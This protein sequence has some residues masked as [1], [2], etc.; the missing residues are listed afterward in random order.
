L[1][2][3]RSIRRVQAAEIFK[4]YD[5]GLD[6]CVKVSNFGFIFKDLV[7]D[8]HIS[9]KLFFRDV[10]AKLDEE[11]EGVIHLNAFIAWIES[12]SHFLYLSCAVC[13]FFSET[14]LTPQNHCFFCQD[15]A[16]ESISTKCKFLHYASTCAAYLTTIP[17]L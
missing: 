16:S 7:E 15:P 3:A 13:A 17:L 4:A 1:G 9:S 5:G 10:V 11:K 6:G 8:K 14:V 2:D 12:V